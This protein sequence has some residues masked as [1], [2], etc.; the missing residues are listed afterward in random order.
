MTAL[1]LAIFDVDGTLVD[2][3]ADILASM[4]AA[5]ALA[6][7]ALP[8]RRDIL[9]IVGL[10]LPQAMARLAPDAAP[11]DLDAMVEA[12]KTRYADLRMAS[13]SKSA[14]LY[15]GMGALLDRLSKQDDLLM[16]VATGKSRRGLNALI[17]SL[18]LRGC[19]VT[20]QVADDHPSKPHPS[21]VLTALAEAG[22]DAVDAVMIGDTSFDLEMAASAKV[23]A[24]AV[25]WGYHPIERLQGASHIVSSAESLEKTLLDML[26]LTR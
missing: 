5:F 1:K 7:R 25:D 9:G 6:G 16:G 8:Q 15:P 14:P 20:T 21:M 12:Y 11:S 2:S 4:D 18:G 22:V 3:Q 24:I 26:E 13:G 19:F 17:D 10:S 23:R